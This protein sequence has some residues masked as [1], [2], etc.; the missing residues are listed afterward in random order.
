MIYLFFLSEPNVGVPGV[1]FSLYTLVVTVVT[2][3]V[4]VTLSFPFIGLC[5]YWGCS[6]CWWCCGVG[7]SRSCGAKNRKIRSWC[8]CSDFRPYSAGEV[9]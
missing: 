6:C 4:S 5:W 8:P 9:T 1:Y 2:V 3:S 7:W